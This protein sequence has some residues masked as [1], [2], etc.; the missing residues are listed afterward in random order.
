VIQCKE[1]GRGE[2]G[3]LSRV[4]VPAAWPVGIRLG[5]RLARRGMVHDGG[6]FTV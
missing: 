5:G 4:T 3:P 2:E 1:K 6:Y